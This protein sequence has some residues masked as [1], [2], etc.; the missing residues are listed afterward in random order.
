MNAAERLADPGFGN[1]MLNGLREISLPDPIAY[2]PQTVGWAG[3]GIVLLILVMVGAMRGYGRWRATAYRRA[4]LKRWQALATMAQNPATQV[5]ALRAL[6]AV[7]KQTALAIYPRE[8]VAKLSGDA[9]LAFLDQTYSGAG[10]TQGAGPLLINLSYQTDSQIAQ[11]SPAMVDDLF[12][13]TREW[14]DQHR[15]PK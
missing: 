2:R 15:R 3:L 8:T 4:A 7:L 12:I 11:L 9:W 10:F 14:I 6:P 13:L 1:Y 5:A